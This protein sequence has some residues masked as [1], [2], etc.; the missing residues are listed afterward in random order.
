VV[1]VLA[2]FV[3]LGLEWISL[4]GVQRSTTRAEALLW[5]RLITIVPRVSGMALAAIVASGFYSGARFGVLGNE[6]MR[7][8]Y[9]ALVL[10]AIV[11]GPVSRSPM[12][13][14]RYAADT[15]ADGPCR[16][17]GRLR[18]VRSCV[19]LSVFASSLV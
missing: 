16:R 6:W 12:R 5:L 11:S 15:A 17:C 2:L 13:T 19:C 14:L 3:G 10:M 1:G 18:P 7:V 8:S 4:D 9:G